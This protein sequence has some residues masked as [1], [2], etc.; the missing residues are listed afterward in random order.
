MFGGD[1]A[2]DVVGRGLGTCAV[3]ATDF[4]AEEGKLFVDG[5]VQERA[6][7]RV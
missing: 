4:A 5:R 3:A 7:E 1:F 2:V 6:L